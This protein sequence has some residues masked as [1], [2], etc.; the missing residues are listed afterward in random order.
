MQDLGLLNL[1]VVKGSTAIFDLDTEY[2]DCKGIDCSLYFF[3]DV[4]WLMV[5]LHLFLTVEG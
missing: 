4:I 3:S 5:A 2:P 1:L